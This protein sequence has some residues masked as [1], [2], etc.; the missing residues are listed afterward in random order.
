MSQISRDILSDITET[1]EIQYK[2]SNMKKF[3]K[4]VFTKQPS[5]KNY[6]QKP[7]F[8]NDNSITEEENVD[9]IIIDNDA[10]N[11]VVPYLPLKELNKSTG[12][13]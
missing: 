5:F 3:K 7:I 9:K 1:K 13:N 12:G 10:G 6:Y 4:E 11:G 2:E 8:I